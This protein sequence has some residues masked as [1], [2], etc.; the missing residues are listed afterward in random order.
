MR[1]DR[2]CIS[3]RE[4]NRRR[5]ELLR[6]KKISAFP[7]TDRSTYGR[8]GTGICRESTEKLMTA[9]KNTEGK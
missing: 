9:G 8:T 2:S 6:Q 5:A 7:I 3:F 1:R 4:L